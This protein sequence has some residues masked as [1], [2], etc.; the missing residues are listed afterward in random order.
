MLLRGGGFGGAAV[1]AT[2]NGTA[3]EQ[4]E[5]GEKCRRCLQGTSNS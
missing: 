5:T 1:T 2:K 3:N 4:N